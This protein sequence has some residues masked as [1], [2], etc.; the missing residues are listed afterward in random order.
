[1][2]A[3]GSTSLAFSFLFYGPLTVALGFGAVY[4]ATILFYA[5]FLLVLPAFQTIISQRVEPEHQATCQATVSAVATLSAIVAIPLY[6]NVLFNAT[7]HQLG[8]GLCAIVSF[9]LSAASTLLL[10]FAASKAGQTKPLQH[11]TPACN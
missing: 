1:M 7:K 11:I 6:S 10:M 9:C 4:V 2:G 3:I 8:S 5:G